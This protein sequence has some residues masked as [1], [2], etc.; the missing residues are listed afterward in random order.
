MDDTDLLQASRTHQN[1]NNPDFTMERMQ[2]SIDTWEAAAKT[3]GSSIAVDKSWFYLIHFE[4]ENGQWSYGDMDN[5]LNDE[6]NC[7]DKNGRQ[8]HLNYIRAD[9]AKEMLGVFLVPDSNNRQQI[10]EMKKKT[11]YLGELNRYYV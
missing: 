8:Q 7:K 11:T 1:N 6:L 2:E 4:W 5:V 9:Q 10:K 3:T